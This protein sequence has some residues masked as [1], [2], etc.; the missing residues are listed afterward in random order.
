MRDW[1]FLLGVVLFLLSLLFSACADEQ[2]PLA[3]SP[4][5]VETGAASPAQ[6]PPPV[7]APCPS[8]TVE[9]IELTAVERVTLGEACINIQKYRQ[10]SVTVILTDLRG[11]PLAGIPVRIEQVRHRFS[12]GIVGTYLVNPR[13]P[14][15]VRQRLEQPVLD[16]FN[17]LMWTHVTWSHY[18]PQRGAPQHEL[19][20]A[21]LEWASRNRLTIM[22]QTLIYPAP[23]T[24]PEWF[25]QISDPNE[26]LRL[27]EARVRD[28][29]TR[30]RGRVAIWYVVNEPN[31]WPL[32]TDP[33]GRFLYGPI[34]DHLEG[35]VGYVDPAFRWAR[36][37]DPEAVL[38]LNQAGLIGGRHLDRFE[39]ILKELKRRGT[40]FDGVGV[41][42]H[43][44]SEGRV[45]LDQ[46]WANL[47]RL[48][49]YGRLYITEVTV[50]SRPWGPQDLEDWRQ[51][52]GDEES[53]RRQ[54]QRW[55]EGWTEQRQ[56][57]YVIALYTL[58]FGHPAVE[59]INYWDFTELLTPWVRS[60][61]LLRRDLTPRPAY[62]ALKRL[63][64]EEWWTRWEGRTDKS[65]SLRL[66]AFYG[67]YTL[68]ATLSEGSSV[69]LRFTVEEKDEK[70]RLTVK[71]GR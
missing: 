39:V 48:A 53:A 23:H 27:S 54:L 33:S 18:E 12:F 69:E 36:E 58:A 19:T 11:K 49:Q 56:A 6:T 41:Q 5:T 9:G 24:F 71:E 22:G 55:W 28:I 38:L 68:I 3:G 32:L 50:P 8:S 66:Q 61:P 42:A 47:S 30:F 64:R 14:L 26:R 15:A 20:E 63:I 40:P 16:V 35:V 10:T 37:S 51:R 17:H 21:I 2:R 34:S 13:I 65:G 46:V 59:G 70:I 52:L 25:K 45:P 29:V 1:P 57:A 43:M 31:F 4:P 60:A 67:D 7:A 62:D 44:A